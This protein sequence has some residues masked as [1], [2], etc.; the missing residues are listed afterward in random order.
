MFLLLA[1]SE[2]AV[3][4]SDGIP[5]PAVPED[6]FI[7]SWSIYRDWTSQSSNTSALFYIFYTC[8]YMSIYFM[9]NGRHVT[10]FFRRYWLNNPLTGRILFSMESS[11][12]F[13]RK[14]HVFHICY[15]ATPWFYGEVL[16]E[17]MKYATDFKWYKYVNLFMSTLD[18]LI[19][20]AV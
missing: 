17:N 16:N 12:S 6:C 11:F 5:P 13:S 20:T 14:K 15:Q 7:Y 18:Y 3:L 9:F 8:T 2:K 4:S 19:L 1:L 10:L